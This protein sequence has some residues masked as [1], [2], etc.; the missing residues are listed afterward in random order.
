MSAATRVLATLVLVAL[1]DAALLACPICFRMDEG[2]VS[3]GIRAAVFV[4]L[5][6]T[7]AV[8]TG[9]GVWIARF[10]KRARES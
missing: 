6:V 1:S 5:G 7:T 4:L 9:F 10:V 3:E 8:L 2:P